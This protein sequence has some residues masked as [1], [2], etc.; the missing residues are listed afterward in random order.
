M[1]RLLGGLALGAVV[2]G[3]IA[4]VLAARD[5]SRPPAPG[6]R[7]EAVGV[8]SP[9]IL[10]FGDTLAAHVDVTLDRRRIDPESVRVQAEF[11][12]WELVGEPRVT[13]SDSRGTT[14]VRTSWTLRCLISPCVPARDVAPLEFDSAFVTYGGGGPIE[15]E[16]PVLYVHSRLPAADLTTA[17]AVARPWRADLVSLPALSYRVPPG[18]LLGLL[19]A[20]AAALA[21]A[22]SVLGHRALPKRR[23]RPEP[24]PEPLPPPPSVIEQALALLEDT[25]REDGAPDRRRAL[26]LIADELAARSDPLARTGQALAWSED[27]PPAA[28]TR[29]FA[30]GARE[31]LGMGREEHDAEA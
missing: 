21:V 10:L 25:R 29:G 16:W 5:E 7:I 4:A 23:P 12:P 9:R 2:V 18:V 11:T 30:A 20:A 31:A 17:E 6:Y 24:P 15:V 3:A 1:S 28:E 19:L 14:L 22:G 26:E 13:R 8:L 27:M